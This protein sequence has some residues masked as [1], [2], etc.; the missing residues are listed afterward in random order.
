MSSEH[1]D[2]VTRVDIPF[3]DGLVRTSAQHVRVFDE[4]CVYVV[5]VAFQYANALAM[6]GFGTPKARSLVFGP[7]DQN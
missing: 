3:S 2:T 5:F 4:N 6:R 1:E 7:S